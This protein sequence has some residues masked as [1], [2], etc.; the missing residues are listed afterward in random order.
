[1]VARATP[2]R[3]IVAAPLVAI[4]LLGG[5]SDPGAGPN[6]ADVVTTGPE[7]GAVVTTTPAAQATSSPT[8]TEPAATTPATTDDGEEHTA[9][10]KEQDGARRT[11]AASAAPD[12]TAP[13]AEPTIM[14]AQ[15]LKPR[16]QTDRV[17]L[18][19]VR[20]MTLHLAAASLLAQTVEERAH[21]AKLRR[22]ASR[23]VKRI[24]TA[25]GTLMPWGDELGDFLTQAADPEHVPGDLRTLGAPKGAMDQTR[26][27]LLSEEPVLA[28]KEGPDFDRAAVTTMIEHH[29]S[30][31]AMSSGTVQTGGS[32]KFRRFATRD[33][34]TKRHEIDQ[35]QAFQR[36]W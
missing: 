10:G 6:T 11:P 9:P 20:E 33:E 28:G 31:I 27:L 35:L 29:R 23:L 30:A 12:P 3:P 19:Y 34:R 18:A 24:N 16:A 25:A 2:L 32:A 22:F 13:D 7:P 21:D 4:A 17:D 36:S 15:T 5:C 8:A 14:P 26:A 1:L